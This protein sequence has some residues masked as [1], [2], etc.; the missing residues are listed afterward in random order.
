MPTGERISFEQ[1]QRLAQ[2]EGSHL[3]ALLSSPPTGGLPPGFQ[4]DAPAQRCWRPH[5]LCG[6]QKY[7]ASAS[8]GGPNARSSW[9]GFNPRKVVEERLP[10]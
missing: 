7:R 6:V 4:L 3:D 10:F 8:D 5:R 2:T 1:A 9:R